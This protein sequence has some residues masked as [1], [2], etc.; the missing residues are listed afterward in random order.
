MISIE[1]LHHKIYNITKLLLSNI[2]GAYK[3]LVDNMLKYI[4]KNTNGT[5]DCCYPKNN[6][7][8]ELKDDGRS[9]YNSNYTV[10]DIVN[11]KAADIIKSFK[12][13]LKDVS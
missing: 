5:F 2:K 10:Y 13:F 11:G 4:N 12:E 6:K 7:D 3:L 9:I 1:I 8:K